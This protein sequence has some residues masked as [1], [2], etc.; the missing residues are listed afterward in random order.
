MTILYLLYIIKCVYNIIIYI[1][2]VVVVSSN[3]STHDTPAAIKRYT[4]GGIIILYQ[5]LYTCIIQV[6]TSYT[7]RGRRRQRFIRRQHNALSCPSVADR[8]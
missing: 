8:V 4:G 1:I 3:N 7:Y 6:G 2:I 5:T